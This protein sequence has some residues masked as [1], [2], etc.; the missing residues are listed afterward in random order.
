MGKK[1]TAM[2]WALI[3]QFGGKSYLNFELCIARIKTGYPFVA[4]MMQNLLKLAFRNI[5][6]WCWKQVVWTIEQWMYHWNNNDTTGWYE[7]TI[8]MDSGDSSEYNMI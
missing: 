5:C 2:C 4:K 7:A 1:E 6:Q 3:I 8:T